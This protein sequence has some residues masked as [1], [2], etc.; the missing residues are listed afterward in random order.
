MA[1]TFRSVLAA[2]RAIL[3]NKTVTAGTSDITVQ[4][5]SGYDGLGTVTVQPT[6]TETGS[7]T[8]TTSAQTVTPSSGKHLSSVS[9]G[10]IPSQYVVPTNITPSNSSPVSLTSGSAYKPSANGYA[11]SSY[12]SVTPSNSS[13]VSLTSGSIYKMSGAGK[14]VASVTDITPSS[15]SQSVS[16]GG[17]YKMG[18]N[19][20]VVSSVP[21][22]TSITP[23]DSS[24]VA[25]A[26]TGNYNPT[27]SG[28]AVKNIPTG[29][30]TE[31]TLWT[32]SSPTSTFA[33]QTVTLTGGSISSSTYNYI[34]VTWRRGTSASDTM[35][36]LCPTSQFMTGT[37]KTLLPGFAGSGTTAY[38]YFRS[39]TY[40]S[41][42]QVYFSDA[43][44]TSGQTGNTHAIPVYIKGYK[45]K[46]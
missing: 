43:K 7:A 9:V 5:D 13:P 10:A 24:P 29:G 18:G 28:Y 27:T 35:T 21:T 15:T 25:L 2:A 12:S 8:P 39:F 6:P 16:S 36:V 11:I 41:A 31:T 44:N 34:G 22:I 30:F 42:T 40:T 46:P 1:I 26:T 4:A 23:S 38:V 3:Q 17:V 33:A 32:N 20:V 45:F 37:N 14:A 19:G